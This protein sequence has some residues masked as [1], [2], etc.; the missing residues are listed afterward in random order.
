MAS[1][2]P[3]A[4]RAVLLISLLFGAFPGFAQLVRVPGANVSI[5]V[6]KLGVDAQVGIP[7]VEVPRNVL[8]VSKTL[9]AITTQPLPKLDVRVEPPVVP[10]AGLSAGVGG[11]VGKPD[12]G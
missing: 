5:A 1:H 3:C 11:S 8:D 2:K 12:V 4:L 7:R 10:G 6:P 9:P